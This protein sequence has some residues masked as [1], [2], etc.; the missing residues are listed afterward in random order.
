MS[1]LLQVIETGTFLPTIKKQDGTAITVS[2]GYIR[3]ITY[4]KTDSKVLT[5]SLRQDAFQISTSSVTE[6]HFLFPDLDF[7]SEE[8]GVSEPIVV[9]LLLLLGSGPSPEPACG[10]FWYSRKNSTYDVPYLAVGRTFPSSG[11]N[12][13][14]QASLHG[15]A[16]STASDIKILGRGS[17]RLQNS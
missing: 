3:P 17:L 11:G 5:F 10:L 2:S 1:L 4:E 8:D 7:E 13:T 9:P 14:G 12:I 6:I 15:T 16:F